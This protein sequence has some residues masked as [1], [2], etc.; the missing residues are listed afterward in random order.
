MTEK[1]KAYLITGGVAIVAV[2][3]GSHIRFID[4][5]LYG[6]NPLTNEEAG[7]WV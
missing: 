3:A 2:W 7:Y 1:T 6:A 4:E 5:L